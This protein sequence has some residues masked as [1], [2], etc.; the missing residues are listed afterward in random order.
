MVTKDV[1]VQADTRDIWENAREDK[2]KAMIEAY[3]QGMMPVKEHQQ[4]VK[5]LRENGIIH[6]QDHRDKWDQWKKETK[7]ILKL[8]KQVDTL[9]IEKIKLGLLMESALSAG[10][11]P[12]FTTYLC[13]KGTLCFIG[14]H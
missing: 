5:I 4:I 3:E 8:E 7:N 12:L 1:G 11:L 14:K 13:K 9:K 6:L 10:H 2:L